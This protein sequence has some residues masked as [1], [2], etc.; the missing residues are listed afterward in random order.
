MKFRITLVHLEDNETRTDVFVADTRYHA[1]AKAYMAFVQMEQHDCL[2][3]WKVLAC[4]HIIP[5]Q[6]V[7]LESALDDLKTVLRQGNL[8]N[9]ERQ[10]TRH[11][12]MHCL[13]VLEGHPEERS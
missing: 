11:V 7:S 4:D 2:D 8:T 3:T 12:L 9:D 6:N 10:A 5:D 1:V 13:A